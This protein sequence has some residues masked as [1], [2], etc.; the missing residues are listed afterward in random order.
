MLGDSSPNSTPALAPDADIPSS[1]RLLAVNTV[2]QE[3][4]GQGLPSENMHELGVVCGALELVEEGRSRSF[5]Q[6]SKC[7]LPLGWA[8][9]VRK[10]FASS[11]LLVPC[12]FSE[13]GA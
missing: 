9:E 4:P 6:N 8:F 13:D 1:P 7:I 10:V 3:G 11:V 2:N 5:Y 12:S